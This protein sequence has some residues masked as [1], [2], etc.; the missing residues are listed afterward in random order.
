MRDIEK[1]G[2]RVSVGTRE[3]GGL[4]VPLQGTF[5][6]GSLTQGCASLTLGYCPAAL[7]GLR[8]AWIGPVPRVFPGGLVLDR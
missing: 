1:R 8:E 7:S 3:Q 4:P 6:G 5:I 2:E